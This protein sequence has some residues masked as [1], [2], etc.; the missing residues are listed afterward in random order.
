MLE[1]DRLAPARLC[2]PLL[3]LLCMSAAALPACSGSERR[4]PLRDPIWKDSDLK[5]VKASCP[6]RPDPERSRPRRLRAGAIV[7]ADHLGR[8]GQPG[9]PS[10][11][12][13][14]RRRRHGGE[15]VDVNS[16]DEVPDSSWFTN[17]IGVRPMSA[18]GAARRRLHAASSSSTPSSAPTARGSSTRARATAR[19]TAFASTSPARA[20]TCSRPRT[21]RTA[22][23]LERRAD[24]SARPSTTPPATTRPAS[25][26]STSAA[27]C[28]SSR[29]G[30]TPEAQLRRREALRPEGARQGPRA[31]RRSA[32]DARADA[33]VGVAP[34]VHHRAASATRGRGRD[35]PNDV[36]PA[37][38][39]ARA[40]RRCASSPRGSTAS[41]RARATRSTRGSPSAQERAR[42]V[43][44][45][46]RSTTSSTRARRSAPS[47]AGTAISRAPRLLVH[48][49]LGR[50]R[51]GLRHARASR[52]APV[53]HARSKSRAR[54][55][56]GTSTSTTSTPTS[57]RTSTRTPRSAG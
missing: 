41:T 48:P 1:H 25:R 24:R 39:S 53:G 18:R 26:S 13:G 4:F 15:A 46:R 6:R 19:P 44:R 29:P 34:G 55:S 51:R 49:R 50:H 35:D 45:A 21:A 23:A 47:G 12:R 30:L 8:R 10:A 36:D 42:R 9:L 11:L 16:L 57:G 17:R 43:A 31:L 37:R 5:P 40:A 33:G 28:S 54:R 56:S 38:G 32:G 14:A 20:S 27:R 52:I 22:R 7:F 3:A 2:G